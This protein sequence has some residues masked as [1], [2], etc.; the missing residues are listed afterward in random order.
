MIPRMYIDD[1]IHS[2]QWSLSFV[3]LHH[4][5]RLTG[6]DAIL[7]IIAHA[8]RMHTGKPWRT[9]TCMHCTARCCMLSQ[10]AMLCLTLSLRSAILAPS[11]ATYL[12]KS[13]ALWCSGTCTT[14]M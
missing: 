11:G 8:A 10:T 6:A 3:L 5:H 14:H 1:C 2:K 7:C 4:S 12:C 9:L 13:C